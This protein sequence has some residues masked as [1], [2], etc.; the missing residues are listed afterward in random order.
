[1]KPSEKQLWRVLNASAD[2]ILDVELDYD[3]QP[4][5]LQVVALDGVPLGS[6]D[7]IARGSSLA[8][9]H[10]FLSPA[11]RAEFIVT[12]PSA[13]VKSAIFKTLSIDTGPGGDNDPER[14]LASVQ[15]SSSATASARPLPEVSALPAL[16]RF[17]SLA[18]A[19]PTVT[20][21][22]YFSEVS[23]DPFDADDSTIFFITVDGQQPRP[24]D[25]SN[26]PAIVTT[27]GAVEDWTIENRT[28]ENHEFHIHQIH[29]LV[30][31]NSGTDL[32]NGQ[33]L[34]TIDVPYWSGTGPYP[35]VTLRHGFSRRLRGLRL[36][37]PHPG[38]RRWRD[39]GHHP[40]EPRVGPGPLVL[41]LP[42]AMYNVCAPG[43]PPSV[44]VTGVASFAA[45]CGTVT[46]N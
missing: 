22:I 27:E 15:V 14:P 39:D 44:N 3:S 9:T 5:P 12:G 26:P 35:S 33:Y 43:A 38:A 25:P 37:L 17:E 40:R 42:I 31:N 46:L 1:M 21:K 28:T 8:Q 34:D 19:A 20:R 36:P 6:Q 32:T 16:P 11:G 18:T 7:G 4:Q 30:M 23:L 41:Q 24:F 13:A 10:V 2:T 29:F 45:T